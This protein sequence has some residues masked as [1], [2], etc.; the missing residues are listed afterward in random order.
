MYRILKAEQLADKIYL[1][2]VE[3][4]RV[5]NGCQ[6]GEFVIVKIDE[7]GER[8]PLTICDF[9]RKKGTVTIVFQVV[10]A[11]T[12]R[13]SMLKEGDAFQDFVGPLGQPSEFVREPV[14]EVMNRRYLFVAGGVGTAP[15]YPQVKWMKENGISADVIIGAKNKE[16]LILE[17]KMRDVAGNLYVT[18]D[19]G[20]YERKGMVTAVIQDLIENQG[21][22]YDVCVAIGPMIMMKFVCKL[23]KALGIPTVVSMNPIMVDGTGMCGACRLTIGKEVKFACVDGPEFDGHL[24]D[25]DEAM[26]RQQM[27][28]TE[29]GRA[30]LKA[31]EGETH[32]GGCGRC[33]E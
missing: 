20:S 17:D 16:L 23:T 12:K 9:E 19:D 32:H 26:K 22:H 31:A 5:A 29:E 18:T 21:L 27:Y 30:M 33:R 4:A 14:E 8:I 3:A 15:V 13:M 28:K 2:E 7:Q 25:F 6:P 10:G 11:S 24:V 1:M